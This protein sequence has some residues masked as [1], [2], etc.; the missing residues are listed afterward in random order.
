[1]DYQIKRSKR[2]T[3]AIHVTPKG[4]EV[5]VPYGIDLPWISEFVASRQA[6]IQHQQARLAERLVDQPRLGFGESIWFMGQP[7]KLVYLQGARKTVCIAGDHLQV[8]APV[9][10]DMAAL[11]SQVTAWF[12]Q[13]AKDY[14]PQHVYGRAQQLG[15]M[16][17]LQQIRFRRTKSKWGHCTSQGNLQFNWQI[18]GAPPEIIDYL[19]CHEVAHLLEHNHSKRFWAHVKALC[20]DY[21]THRKWLQQSGHRL[22]WC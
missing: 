22:I 7:V 19:I 12:L 10:P 16:D 18:M 3:A 17:R 2:K 20:P 21:P 4:V 5:R 11:T 13:Q 14:M 1:M 15:V 8:V 9:R 6:W